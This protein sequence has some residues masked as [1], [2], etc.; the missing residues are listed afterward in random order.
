MFCSRCRELLTSLLSDA[1]APAERADVEAHLATCPNCARELRALQNIGET[2]AALP[3]HEVP[4]RVRENVRAALRAPTPRRAPIGFGWPKFGARPLAWG[5]AVAVGAIGLMLLARPLQNS[6]SF[7]DAPTSGSAGKASNATEAASAPASDVAAP[8]GAAKSG[9]APTNRNTGAKTGNAEAGNTNVGNANAGN[10]EAGNTE[11]GNAAANSKAATAQQLAPLKA[12]LG[13]SVEGNADAAAQSDFAAPAPLAPAPQSAQPDSKRNDQTSFADGFVPRR[14]SAPPA[15]PQTPARAAQTP[16]SPRPKSS[17]G[18]KPSPNLADAAEMT[19][20]APPPPAVSGRASSSQTPRADSAQKTVPDAAPR[21]QIPSAQAPRAKVAGAVAP[22]VTPPNPAPAPVFGSAASSGPLGRADV[23][24][25]FRATASNWTRGPVAVTL[26][27][28]ATP[29][30]KNS[31]SQNNEAV[32][33]S[34]ARAGSFELPARAGSAGA[35]A[36]ASAP[37]PN[38]S[39]AL[40]Q[41][42]P[43]APAT[44]FADGHTQISTPTRARRARCQQPPIGRHRFPNTKRRRRSQR[45]RR[46]RRVWRPKF[47]RRQFGRGPEFVFGRSVCA[48]HADPARLPN[49]RPGAFGAARAPGRNRNLARNSDPDSSSNSA[50]FGGHSTACAPQWPNHPRAFGTN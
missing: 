23:Q 47:E 33:G 38:V 4:L 22:K 28:T 49:R 12:N 29:G 45:R 27:R 10:T 3:A 39:G 8:V 30:T 37:K 17:A 5:G 26:T 43:A 46:G 1:L 40:G 34:R 2:L 48:R 36:S 14:K 11:A 7:T 9:A 18:Q 6:P 25:S 19:R 35:G 21:A 50:L 42:A 20:A 32:A 24:G 41:N 13:S 31:A 15:A 16:A 44:T